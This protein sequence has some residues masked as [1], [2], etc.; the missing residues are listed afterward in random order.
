MIAQEIVASVAA[1]SIGKD[2]V[3]GIRVDMQDHV[4]GMIP[5]DGGGVGGRIVQQHLA[6]AHSFLGGGGLGT[7]NLV[8]GCEHRGVNSARVVKERSNAGLHVE[9]TGAIELGGFIDGGQLEFL[10]IGWLGPL[11]RCMLGLFG[12]GMLETG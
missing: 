3:G 2:K 9:F 4:A 10:A 7:T 5:K 12:E 11:V 6:S 1:A 8:D